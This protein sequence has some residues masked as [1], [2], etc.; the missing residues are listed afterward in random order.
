LQITV[1][2]VQ[3]KMSAVRGGCLLRTRQMGREVFRYAC[4]HFFVQKTSGFSK[5]MVCPHGQRWFSPVRTWG[6]GWIFRDFARMSFMDGP[7]RHVTKL[8][9][10]FAACGLYLNI[11]CTV[12]E[13]SRKINTQ[14]LLH[15][16]WIVGILCNDDCNQL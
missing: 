3:K 6:K 10:L 5:F 15:S 9:G 14:D 13:M 4:L 2:S 7:L 11:T 16:N 8:Y 1:G 12:N